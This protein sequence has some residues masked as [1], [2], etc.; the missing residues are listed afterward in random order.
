MNATSLA[1]P[2]EPL[3]KMLST[4]L[5]ASSESAYAPIGA[6]DACRRAA[7]GR[8]WLG[9]ISA[10]PLIPVKTAGIFPNCRGASALPCAAVSMDD[11]PRLAVGFDLEATG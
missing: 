2:A 5:N 6:K 3:L 11:A 4:M 1:E 8:R 10:P 9:E 7:V